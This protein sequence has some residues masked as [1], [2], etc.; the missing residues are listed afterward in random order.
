[1]S[2]IHAPSTRRFRP[3]RLLAAALLVGFAVLVLT[4]YREAVAERAS[5][6]AAATTNEPSS[7]SRAQAQAARPAA[8]VRPVASQWQPS[9]DLTG[10]LAPLRESSVSFKITGRLASVLVKVGDMVK[11]GQR[12]A[13]LDPVEAAAQLAATNAQV[14]AA[15]VEL[16][17]AQDNERRSQALSQQGAI[18]ASQHLTDQQRA[19]LAQ[20]RLEQA[21][22]QTQTAAAALQNTQLLAPF[23]GLVV[24]APTAPGAIVMTTAPLFRLLDAST[25]RLTATV[26]ADDAALLRVGQTIQVEG[27]GRSGRITAILPSVDEKTRRVPLIAEIDNRGPSP[28]LAGVFV[29]ATVSAGAPI[30]VLRVPA[31]ALRPGSQDELV[32]AKAGKAR[33]VRVTFSRDAEGSLLVRKGLVPDDDVLLAPSS[34]VK[35][36]DELASP[37]P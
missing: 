12:L 1:M 37:P 35:D 25:L 26:S 2:A 27:S 22:A 23:A 34:D 15:D 33:L 3:G 18:S 24:Q 36:G 30:D 20:A 19:E 32:L 10:T 31:T 17:I 13:T 14:H 16:A 9:V 4:R 8:R 7:A 6:A 11:A 29:R 5:F 21:R 28:L